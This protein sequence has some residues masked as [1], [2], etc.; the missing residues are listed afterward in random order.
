MFLASAAR[1]RNLENLR[2]PQIGLRHARSANDAGPARADVLSD[3]KK[4]GQAH[5]EIRAAVSD[6]RSV[7]QACILPIEI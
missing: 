3:G 4:F 1:F 6:G 2:H 5:N 7:Q